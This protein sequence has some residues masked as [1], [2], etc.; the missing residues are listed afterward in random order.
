MIGKGTGT[1]SPM[2]LRGVQLIL[3]ATGGK[4]TKRIFDEAK[5]HEDASYRLE[6]VDNIYKYS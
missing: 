6:T 5:L 2:M 4:E 1:P 3:G